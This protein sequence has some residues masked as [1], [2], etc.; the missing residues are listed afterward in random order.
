MLA[1]WSFE[2]F[3]GE[4]TVRQVS[5]GHR[6]VEE[7]GAVHFHQVASKSDFMEPIYRALWSL[8]K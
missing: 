6:K 3:G 2:C 5:Q 7:V 4:I 8:F 1:I